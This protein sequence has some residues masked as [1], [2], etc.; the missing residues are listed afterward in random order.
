MA[1]IYGCI[2]IILIFNKLGSQ[3]ED[4]VFDL[5][6]ISNIDEKGINLNLKTR[7]DKDQIYVSKNK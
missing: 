3:P 5:T 4:G 7:Y 1:R 2:N 6:L